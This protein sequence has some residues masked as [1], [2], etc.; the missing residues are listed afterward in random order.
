VKDPGRL[1][2]PG[3]FR[4]GPA[5]HH[6]KVDYHRKHILLIRDVP[7][8]APAKGNQN[9]LQTSTTPGAKGFG[10][11]TH[12]VA[13][14]AA[15][16]LPAFAVGA[17][18][19]GA[20]VHGYRATFDDRL[21]ATARA[22]ASA[23][24]A[25]IG[26]HVVAL[27]TL[28]VSRGLDADGDLG[29]FHERA[30]RVADAFGTRI[31]VSTP[32]P[33]VR[34][35]LNTA[36][37]FGA[38]IP[39]ALAADERRAAPASAAMRAFE[40]GGPVVGDL[41]PSR[42][43]DR[44]LVPIYVPVPRSGQPAYAVGM[45]LEPDRLR[46]LLRAQDFQD[47]GYAS[48]VDASGTI[49]ARS[50]EH[51]RFAG[52]RVQDWLADGIR[53]REA[54]LLR[55][56]VN[57][58]GVETI[59]AFH[60]LPGTPGW[61]VVLVEPLAN[62]RAGLWGPL[63]A[64][65]VGGLAALAIAL[66]VAAKIGGR[67][68]RPVRALTRQ[69]EAVVA[70]GGDAALAPDEPA[71]VGEFARLQR[72]VELAEGTLRERAAATAAAE[73]RLRAV[74]DTAVDAIVVIDERGVVRSFNRSAEAIFGYAAEEVAGRNVSML[75]GAEH[76]PRHDG[77][78]AAYRRTGERKIIGVGREVQGRR[79][80][81]SAVPLDLAIAE[82]RDAEGKR[83]FTGIMRDIS[84][85]KAGEARRLLLAREVDHRA[86]NVL[87]V[88]QS[89]LRLTPGDEPRAFVAA[90]EAR[91]AALARAHSL[92]AEG[93][94][95][96]ADLRAVAERE[97]APYAPPRGG[98]PAARGP[99]VALDGPPVPLAP[100]A[101]QPFAMVLHELATNAAKHGALS[102]LGGRVE[103]RWR[104]G[105]RA[106]NDGLLRL[107]WVE[108]GGPALAG[109]PARRGFGSRVIEGTVR[110]QLGGAVERRWEASGLVVE[111]AV[112]IPR[113][114]ADAGAPGDE[115]AAVASAA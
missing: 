13:L 80:D 98:A 21:K 70:S 101:V 69:A 71:R 94:W 10:L 17:I 31:F 1:G 36:L 55:R 99:A 90:V 35:V 23:V 19:V 48:V 44:P 53:D 46:R 29:G 66:L 62:Y 43:T 96:G 100:A 63:A 73:A 8:A 6:L 20:A 4:S 39:S 50:L 89:M 12:L 18:A 11:R 47:G 9:G 85:R 111:V 76:A 110:G 67:V 115:A 5:R 78:L 95:S 92:L 3:F 109:P 91:V 26:S 88:V 114:I 65:A 30:R 42:L 86:K 49:V 33:E 104:V 79:K 77:Y 74:V 81:G 112:P 2:R 82:W 56:T 93:G 102:A 16:L 25:E 87:A 52:K 24:D 27:S 84:A 15:A 14:V 113:A 108:T 64:L 40:T 51:E 41:I 57:L 97:L 107:R 54:G 60:R 32:P 38:G 22:L 34:Q 72:A 37:P 59:T 45:A 75:M 105:R 58:S 83:F 7:G 68:L 61:A 28:A 103:V 106:E